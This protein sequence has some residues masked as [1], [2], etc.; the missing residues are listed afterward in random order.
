MK[1]GHLFGGFHRLFNFLLGRIHLR[2]ESAHLRFNGS[3]NVS[4]SIPKG[5]EG[6]TQSFPQALHILR[7][8]APAFLCGSLFH[9]RLLGLYPCNRIFID[10]SRGSFGHGL[11]P[12]VWRQ[13]RVGSTRRGGAAGPFGFP[14]SEL[15][16]GELLLPGY[17]RL[18]WSTV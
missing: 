6:V 15:P 7:G 3:P 10:H 8:S 5:T 4:R 2:F 14:Y 18:G 11:R 1:S 12:S 13:S 17:A 9:S 16:L